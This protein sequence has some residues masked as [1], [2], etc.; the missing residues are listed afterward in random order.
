MDC[1]DTKNMDHYGFEQIIT[2]NCWENHL[3]SQAKIDISEESKYPNN[4][5]FKVEKSD[6]N[7]LSPVIYSIKDLTDGKS[8]IEVIEII[9]NELEIVHDEVF[10]W[11]KMIR[12]ISQ[13]KLSSDP[14]P[15]S[16]IVF[17]CS[18]IFIH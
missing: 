9:R 4:Q 1:I 18:F 16:E 13:I 6:K 5:K 12:S 15:D 2:N 8:E 7:D 14:K 17:F 10:S 3:S 11:N